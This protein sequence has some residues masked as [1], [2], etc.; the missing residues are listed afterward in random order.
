[1]YVALDLED[2]VAQVG[3]QTEMAYVHKVCWLLLLLIPVALTTVS[4]SKPSVNSK[5]WHSRG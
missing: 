5:S 1:M 3:E 2:N 4:A